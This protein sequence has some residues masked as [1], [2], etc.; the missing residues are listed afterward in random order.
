M[1]QYQH[2]EISIT[3]I[4]HHLG[5]AFAIL[6]TADIV[7]NGYNS[8]SGSSSM[9]NAMVTVFAFSSPRVGNSDFVN[10][11][12]RFN[13]L[14]L[15]HIRLILDIVP[16]LPPTSSYSTMGTV[17]NITYTTYTIKDFL[18]RTITSVSEMVIRFHTLKNLH[19]A[20]EK[21]QEGKF[22]FLS[23]VPVHQFTLF[24]TQPILKKF[25]PQ[26][27][28]VLPMGDT[29]LLAILSFLMI[30]SINYLM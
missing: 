26:Q 27:I 30:E 25:L 2:E 8:N 6:T 5:S 29:L 4:G 1:K 20:I 28:T 14:H 7:A 12:N 3:V 24:P 18:R 16:R 13:N 10:V 19:E 17:L 9:P 11:F 23:L 22:R 21:Q 15:L